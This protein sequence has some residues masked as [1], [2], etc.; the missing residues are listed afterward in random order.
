MPA[1]LGKMPALLG[2]VDIGTGAGFPSLPLLIAG[3]PLQVALVDSV[4]KKTDFCRHIIDVLGLT[5]VSV[6]TARAEDLGRHPPH[7]AQYDLAVSRAVDHL[8]VLAEYL[9]PFCRIGGLAVAMKKGAIQVEI[10]E[11]G[12]ALTLLGG[13][14]REVQP[15]PD[16]PGLGD[17]HVLVIVEKI[18]PT[19]ERYPRRAGAPHKRPLGRQQ[20]RGKRAKARATNL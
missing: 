1:L 6:V 13:G 12:P 20:A 18:V 8:A 7:R 3:L 17:D 14:L 4:G 11:A 19:P 5:G 15:V 9:L 10:A 16:L 2:M